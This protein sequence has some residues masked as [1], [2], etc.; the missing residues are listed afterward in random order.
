MHQ[1]ATLTT[2]TRAPAAGAVDLASQPFKPSKLLTDWRA[3]REQQRRTAAAEAESAR[4]MASMRR[5]GSMRPRRSPAA[6]V[7]SAVQPAFKMVSGA[8]AFGA[9]STDRLTGAWGAT[10]T[11]INADLEAS[12]ATLRARS[13]DWC[14]NTDQGARYLEL[15][16]DNIVGTNAPTLQVRAKLRD[17]SDV[18][19]EVANTAIEQAWAAWCARGVCEMTGQ[20]SFADVC[21]AVVQA[22]ARD[23]EFLAR[24]IKSRSLPYGY[25]LQLLEVDRINSSVNTAIGNTGSTIRMGVELD[26]LG[27]RQALHLY[28]RHPGD[29]GGNLSPAGTPERVSI[30]SLFHGYVL[31]RPEQLRGY[32]WAAAVLRRANTLNTYEGYALE[33]AKFGAAKMGFYTVDKDAVNGAEMTWEQMRDATGELV[34][35]VEG[36]MLEALP[37]GVGFE[38]FDPAYPAEAFNSFVTEYKRDIA[39]GLGVAHHNLSGNMTGVN[40]SS[41]RIAE[42]SERRAWRSLQRWLIDCFVRPVFEDWLTAA[43]FTRQIVLPSGAALPSDRAPKFLAA[44]TFQPPGWAW[45]DP[46]KD[47]KAAVLAM[48]YDVRSLRAFANEQGVDVEDTLADKAALLARYVALKLPVPGWLSGA[49]A[50]GSQGSLPG[51]GAAAPAAAADAPADEQNGDEATP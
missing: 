18:L 43:L 9:G 20:L 1:S 2:A 24:R 38:G 33:A 15:C 39:A 7:E 36:G 8:R 45:V 51:A 10:N 28:N 29:A 25:A 30:D 31:K 32:P 26:T 4:V 5:P 46:E 16:A 21:R 13:R 48:S 27:R 41:A 34:Q 17:G 47:I 40:Y 19:D 6:A 44:A 12:L 14:V 42:L 37:P 3:G 49:V 23:G 11:G 22:T 50:M 35:D